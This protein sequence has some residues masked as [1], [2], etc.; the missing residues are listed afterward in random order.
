MRPKALL[1]GL[2]ASLWLAA[3]AKAEI[4]LRGVSWQAAKPGP[5]RRFTDIRR[6]VV[7]GHKLKG[8][9]RVRLR[10]HNTGAEDEEGILV[11][12][13]LTAQ[14]KHPTREWSAWPLPFHLGQRRI[15]K[16]KAKDVAE[17]S[18]DPT[19]EL[20]LYLKKVSRWGLRPEKIKLRV[21]IEP[22]RGGTGH[23]EILESILP[24]AR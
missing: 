24:V 22:R 21:M 7:V 19:L 13:S 14:L 10:L 11:R 3:P 16:V 18:L 2:A 1:L 12:Y 17:V 8:K 4:K 20:K 6:L 5:G 23:I 9:V 15:P